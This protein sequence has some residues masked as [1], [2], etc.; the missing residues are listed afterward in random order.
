M[1]LNPLTE[2]RH[3]GLADQTHPG[4]CSRVEVVCGAAGGRAGLGEPEAITPEPVAGVSEHPP[5]THQVIHQPLLGRGRRH[6]CN[7]GQRSDHE[8]PSSLLMD[9]VS[10]IEEKWK[11]SA[12]SSVDAPK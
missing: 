9:I 5:H 8:R 12:L 6:A 1:T 7:R 11:I 3:D 2:L 4:A 10:C